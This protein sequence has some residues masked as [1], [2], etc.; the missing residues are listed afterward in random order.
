[1]TLPRRSLLLGA[2]TALGASG[3]SVLP[4][5]PYT[6]RRDWPILIANPDPLPARRGGPVLLVRDVTAAPELDRRGVQTLQPDGSLAVD[7]YEE[8]SVLPTDGVAAALR[9]WLSG[10]GLYAAVIGSGSQLRA[11]LVLEADLTRF[12]AI[13]A[14]GGGS[15]GG[16]STGRGAATLDAVLLDQRPGAVKVRLQRSFSA[17][18]PMAGTGAAAAT[19]AILAALAAV[20]RQTTLALAA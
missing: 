3:C 7:F 12:W 16:Y 18:V 13:A 5:V 10:S 4:T 1:M 2:A 6:Q 20:F 11:D 17:E 8:W 14:T 15:P 19:H 9:Q